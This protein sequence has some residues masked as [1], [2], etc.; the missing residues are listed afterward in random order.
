MLLKLSPNTS[1]FFWISNGYLTENMLD[2]EFCKELIIILLNFWVTIV[3]RKG[4]VASFKTV[5]TFL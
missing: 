5:I 3:W 2:C 1:Q 4:V